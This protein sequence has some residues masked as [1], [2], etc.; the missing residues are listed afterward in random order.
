MI[1]IFGKNSNLGA[2]IIQLAVYN[3]LCKLLK[4]RRMKND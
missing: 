1:K 2:Y 4:Q 3:N